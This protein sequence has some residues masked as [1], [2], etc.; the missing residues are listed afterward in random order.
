MY[1]FFYFLPK[2]S[3]PIIAQ[4]HELKVCES[5]FERS[6]GHGMAWY[7]MKIESFKTSK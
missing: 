2:N 1:V 4:L 6:C 7:G 5:H 3:Q